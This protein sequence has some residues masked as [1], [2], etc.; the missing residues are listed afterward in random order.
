MVT[1]SPNSFASTE[2]APGP[3]KMSAA[4]VSILK[5]KT[6]LSGWPAKTKFATAVA[7][8]TTA[9]TGVKKPRQSEN[10]IMAMRETTAQ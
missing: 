5:T 2:Y 6:K 3:R 7:H 10:E 4:E 9:R 8:A 1:R